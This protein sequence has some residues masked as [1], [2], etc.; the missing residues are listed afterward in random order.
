MGKLTEQGTIA[1]LP[2]KVSKKVYFVRS[3]NG[4]VADHGWI[5]VDEARRKNAGDRREF[6][7][8]QNRYFID[9]PSAQNYMTTVQRAA[10]GFEEEPPGAPE[11]P[12]LGPEGELGP[13]LEGPE[14]PPPELPPGPPGLGEEP[15]LG[16]DLSDILPEEEPG[17][18]PPED[19]GG[20]P[21]PFAEPEEE[22][23]IEFIVPKRIR[24]RTEARRTL[25][26]PWERDPRSTEDREETRYCPSCRTEQSFI[27][28][29]C[30]HC[31]TYQA[32]P[33]ETEEARDRFPRDKFTGIES[34]RFDTD[35]GPKELEVEYSYEPGDPS[36]GAGPV[37]HADSVRDTETGET[38]PSE[39]AFTQETGLTFA[40]VEQEVLGELAAGRYE[41]ESTE[42][43]V[44][45]ALIN[46]DLSARDAIEMLVEQDWQRSGSEV[47]QV[48]GVYVV[49]HF[50]GE[51]AG[52]YESEDEALRAN[53]PLGRQE[54]RADVTDLLDEGYRLLSPY[55]EKCPPLGKAATRA[56]GRRKRGPGERKRAAK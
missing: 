4:M 37:L 22:E 53:Q 26:P 30:Q 42:G 19:T 25:R 36:V 52:P 29:V 49:D 13:G 40:D 8:F 27:E 18:L 2:L 1:D 3:E 43:G 44:I 34:V 48:G 16:G 51:V 9:Q 7:A 10:T 54:L 55:E 28:D 39:E 11:G 17:E 31:H 12:P 33:R 56:R 14:G 21:P 46:G 20:E 15:D 41:S 35:Y 6:G 32:L 24:L 38:Y 5:T 50:K 23:E 45:E 47:G